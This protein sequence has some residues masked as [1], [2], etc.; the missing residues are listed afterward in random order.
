[1]FPSVNEQMDVIKRGVD[2]IIPEEELVQKLERSIKTDMPLIIKEGFDP[3]APDLHL[4]HMVSIRKLWDF[5]VLG[6]TVVFLIGD[7]TGLVGDPSGRNETR[8]MMTR[9]EIAKN[10]ETYKEQIFR[11]LNPVQTVI[12]FNSE[13]LGQ[14][15]VYGFLE[16]ASKQTVA[17]MLERDDFKKRFENEID[18]SMLEFMYPLLQGY[19]S[20][21][22]KADVELGGTDQKFNLLMARLIQKR[23]E[24]KSQVIITLP[25]L[26]GI[27]GGEKMSKSLN[28]YIGINESPKEMYGKVM[29]IPDTLIYQYFELATRISQEELTRIKIQFENN[30]INPRDLKK[31]LAR[32][33][34]IEYYGADEA[35][36]AEEEFDRVFKQKAAPS[37]IEEVELPIRERIWIIKLLSMAGMIQSNGEGRRL[38][39]QGAVSV[40]GTIIQ[41]ENS[42]IEVTDGAIIKAGKRTFKKIKIIR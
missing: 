8:R 35:Q 4:G 29:S 30:S 2:E 17:R 10:A 16:L 36:A 3:T 26:E 6:H 5:Q 23:Y 34:I 1:M 15:T 11:V 38:V 28:N 7:F 9:E 18:I 40:N 19:D 21:A 39:R 33:I 27:R 14:L 32:E 31:K 41:D 25:L 24:Q 13:W 37:D 42:E 12:R 20:V 22:L